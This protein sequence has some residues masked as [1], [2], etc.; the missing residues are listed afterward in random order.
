MN[1]IAEKYVRLV[2]ALGQHDTD[3]VDAYYGPEDEEGG[4][5]RPS[6]RSTPLRARTR[7]LL[8]ALEPRAG[9]PR[10]DSSGC[11]TQYLEKQLAR[12][13]RAGRAC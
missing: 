12:D 2:L 13:E 10:R 4:R 8:D 6:C 5:E 7:T 9:A 1:G 3:Y 11:A